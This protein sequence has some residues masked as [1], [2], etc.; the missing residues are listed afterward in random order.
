MIRRAYKDD[1]DQDGEEQS[2]LQHKFAG[3]ERSLQ[4]SFKA[5]QEL[6]EVVA[7]VC[8]RWWQTKTQL[9]RDQSEKNSALRLV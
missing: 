2:E 1:G 5:K 9:D 6:L 3:I 4:E 7:C 8:V